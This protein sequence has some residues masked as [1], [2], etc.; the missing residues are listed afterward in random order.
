MFYHSVHPLS[1]II[2]G[3][4]LAFI[5]V[6]VLAT[7]FFFY[8]EKRGNFYC[9]LIWALVAA[10]LVA[11]ILQ[12]HSSTS[13]PALRLFNSKIPLC[14]I[15]LAALSMWWLLP[16]AYEAMAK[17]FT[18]LLPLAGLSTLWIVPEL[19]YI[20]L[21]HKAVEPVS[22]HTLPNDQAAEAM[23]SERSPRIVWLVFDELSYDQ[24]FEH[25][26]PGLVMPAFDQLKGKS[27]LFQD[28]QPVAYYT[29]RAVLSL[30]L[31]QV[32]DDVRGDLDGRA[33]IKLFGQ[34]DWKVLDP[35]ATLFEDAKRNG[36]ASGLAG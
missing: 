5:V 19:L 3:A 23:R 33:V 7:A 22:A 24:T 29:E 4:L 10:R 2:W 8:L 34:K 16:R 31:G 1:S 9:N 35:R 28:V 36:W 14:L 26:F 27:F 30:L 20:G 21:R 11:Q 32:V 17:G 6:S 13:W 18:I 25:R 15:L 12:V